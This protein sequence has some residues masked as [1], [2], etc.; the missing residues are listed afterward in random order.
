M[1]KNLWVYL[2]LLVALG[3]TLSSP[4]RRSGSAFR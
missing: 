3:V 2:V 1:K 4:G